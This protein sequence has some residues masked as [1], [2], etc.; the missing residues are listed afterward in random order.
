MTQRLHCLGEFCVYQTGKTKGKKK[1]I[2]VFLIGLNLWLQ[3]LYNRIFCWNATSLGDSCSS[4]CSSVLLQ[5]PL[6]VLDLQKHN[7]NP[8]APKSPSSINLSRI[9]TLISAL[10]IGRIFK[11]LT[12]Q[13]QLLSDSH[14]QTWKKLRFLLRLAP[15][16]PSLSMHNEEKNYP[17]QLSLVV[18]TSF[19]YWIW[20]VGTHSLKHAGL[21]HIVKWAFLTASC[22]CYSSW[23]TCSLEHVLGWHSSF[24]WLNQLV[25][26]SFLCLPL[27]IDIPN[28]L[29]KVKQL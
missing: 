5:T 16:G 19:L 8:V 20:F 13:W 23:Y 14:Q 4:W 3:F 21:L 12:V 2:H 22:L 24:L 29:F 25:R 10:N 9:N 27:P 18:R 1:I 28:F 15:L 6:S 11:F 26:K 17:L 7:I